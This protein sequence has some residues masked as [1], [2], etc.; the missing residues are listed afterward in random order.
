MAIFW[1]GVI[2]GLSEAGLMVW[3]TWWPVVLGF[4]L[5]GLVQ[6]AVPRDGLRAKMGGTGVAPVL[7]ATI[8]GVISSSCSYAASAMA[9]ALFL[10]GARFRHSIIFMVASTNLVVELGIVL[11]LLLGWPFFVAEVVGGL[12]MIA[13]LAFLGRVLDQGQ[14]ELRASLSAP[15]T[16]AVPAT[17]WRAALRAR[18]TWERGAGYVLGDLTMLRVELAAGFLVAGYLTA[19]VPDTWWSHLFLT[20]HGLWSTV[21]NAVVAPLVAVLSFVCSVGNVPLAAALWMRGVAFGGVVAFIFADLVTLPLLLAYRR[22][23]NTRTAIRLGLILW[24]VMSTAG[25][26]TQL[27]FGA[28]HLT[29]AVHHSALMGARITVGPTLFLNVAATAALLA[30]WWL[31]RHA[32]PSSSTAIDPVCHMQVDLSVPAAT[33]RHEGTLYYFCSPSCGDSFAAAPTKYLTGM[34]S[35]PTGRAI[36]P[37]CGMRVDPESAAAQVTIDGVTTYFCAPGCRDTFLAGPT[38]APGTTTISL[39]RK[40]GA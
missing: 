16:E 5:S 38:A 13:L 3:M 20:G 30:W 6:A 10:R 23:Y 31:R 11:W 39:G 33:Y 27:L 35:S 29:P 36:D 8:L 40:P 18:S 34:V 19:C 7:W 17:S 25:V 32:A 28:T 1:H 4:S 37:V 14:D 9:R 2:H 21:E 24:V 12:I 22:L 26:V 15:E